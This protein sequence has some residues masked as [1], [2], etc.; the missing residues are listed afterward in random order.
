MSDAVATARAVL[1]AD[2]TTTAIVPAERIE[3]LRRTQ[4]F[5]V[6]AITLQNVTKVPVNH[7]RGWGG[8]DTNVVQVDYYA[9]TYTEAL[10]L[11]AAARTAL[12]AGGFLMRDQ[13]ERNEPETDPE[14]FQM[15]QTWSVFTS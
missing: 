7:L 4:S 9:A 12:E 2:A 11:A 14:L 6:P 8:I 3:A 10:T 1:I 5:E 13:L 15:T